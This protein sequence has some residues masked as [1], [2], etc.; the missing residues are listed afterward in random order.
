MIGDN[1]RDGFGA[2]RLLKAL[3]DPAPRHPAWGKELAPKL[4]HFHL[5][6]LWEIHLPMTQTPIFLGIDSLQLQRMPAL[7]VRTAALEILGLLMNHS[8]SSPD[9][10]PFRSHT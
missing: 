9:P 1:A 8:L 4:L 7:A 3:P 5:P 10:R 6:E 2:G